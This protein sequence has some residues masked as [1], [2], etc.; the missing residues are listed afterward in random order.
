MTWLDWTESD[1]TGAVTTGTFATAPLDAG[2]SEHMLTLRVNVKS[3]AV[4]GRHL[5]CTVLA[6]SEGNSVEDRAG[7]KLVVP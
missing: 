3:S 7:Y 4:S 6:T 5:K 1:V 2:W